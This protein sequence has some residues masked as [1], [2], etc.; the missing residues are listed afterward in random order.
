MGKKSAEYVGKPRSDLRA[1]FLQPSVPV[2]G[3]GAVGV[4]VDHRPCASGSAPLGG[5]DDLARDDELD[6]HG[7]NRKIDAANLDQ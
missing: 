3:A 2:A 5:A 6:L 1:S 4:G 7:T